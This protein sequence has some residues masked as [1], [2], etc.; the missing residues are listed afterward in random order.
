MAMKGNERKVFILNRLTYECDRVN[1]ISFWKTRILMEKDISPNDA[2]IIRRVI[3]DEKIRLMEGDNLLSPSEYIAKADAAAE[4]ADAIRGSERS[5]GLAPRQNFQDAIHDA[6]MTMARVSNDFSKSG[7]SVELADDLALDAN[8]A[9][10]HGD[11]VDSENGSGDPESYYNY[12]RHKVLM[13]EAAEIRSGMTESRE[14]YLGMAE[15]AVKTAENYD[16]KT[17]AYEAAKNGWIPIGKEAA[18]KIALGAAEG[19]RECAEAVAKKERVEKS[20]DEGEAANQ[21][22]AFA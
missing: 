19:Y 1:D 10:E 20:Y 13:H 21:E 18:R 4:K 17:E 3:S 12:G 14:Y 22:R 2:E 15:E 6:Y 11:G 16:E 8:M 9:I 5:E 7:D